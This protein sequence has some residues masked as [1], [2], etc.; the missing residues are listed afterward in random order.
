M[1]LDRAKNR[2]QDGYCLWV[3]AG[4]TK[5]LWPGAPQWGEL[6]KKLEALAEL[7][8]DCSLQYPE[9]LGRCSDKL[10]SDLFRKHLRKIYYTDLCEALL[11]RAAQSLE[12]GDGIPPES[13]KVA[14]LGQLANPIVSFN[15]EP[16]SSTLLARS[17]GPARIIP[18]IN[19]QTQR[20]AFREFVK[21]F[22]RIVYHP[23]GLSTVDCIMTEKDYENLDGTL[24]FELAVHTAFGN[25]L[26]IVGM[27]LQDEYLRK[28]IQKFRSQIDSITWFNS[29]FGDLE[30]WARCNQVEM[31]WVEW[32]KFWDAWSAADVPE[33]DLM[34]A[35]CRVVD[36]AAEEL[37][38][39]RAY[40]MAQLI[41]DDFLRNKMLEYS[42]RIGEPGEL[43]LVDGQ[44]PS[45]ICRRFRELLRSKNIRIPAALNH[46]HGV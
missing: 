36:A 12:D 5:Q 9:R 39:G 44:A 19:P 33:K 1:D 24:A 6:T 45:D 16:F 26:A 2:L 4:V 10:G 14:A 29:Q 31:V 32:S 11:R 40:R 38:G 8:D 37:S 22:Q 43:R 13:R 34:I 35:C 25:H 21:T 3:G 23:H 30:I 27:S 20:I 46:P 41:S 7:G 15:I 17:A 28:Q 18:F 42:T